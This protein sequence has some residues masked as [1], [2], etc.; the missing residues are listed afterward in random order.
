MGQGES[1]GL[2]FAPCH[3]SPTAERAA[4]APA[5]VPAPKLPPLLLRGWAGARGSICFVLPSPSQSS[6]PKQ[7]WEGKQQWWGRGCGAEVV[8]AGH[9][10]LDNT[11]VSNQ[12]RGQTQNRS[13]CPSPACTGNQYKLPPPPPLCLARSSC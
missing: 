4:L 11:C 3:L 2:T 12:A 10:A 6:V 13:H 1:S 5:S 9:R 7:Q 8:A